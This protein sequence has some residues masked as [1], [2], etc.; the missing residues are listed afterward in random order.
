MILIT[1]ASGSV[2]KTVLQEAC[3]KESKSPSDVQVRGGGRE[4]ALG[5]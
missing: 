4:G 5:M 3:R 1:G 2:G